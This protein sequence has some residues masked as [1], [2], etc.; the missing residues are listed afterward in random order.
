MNASASIHEIIAHHDVKTRREQNQIVLERCFFCEDKK[1]HFYIS[2][3]DENHPWYCHKCGE[4]GNLITLCRRLDMGEP[5]KMSRV[6]ETIKAGPENEPIPPK[7][8]SRE[9]AEIPHDALLGDEH[10]A[11]TELKKRGFTEETI[12]HFKIGVTTT[13]NSKKSYSPLWQIP[14]YAAGM[15]GQSITCVKYRTIPPADKKMWREAGMDSPLYNAQNIDY[16]ADRVIL[17]EGE[18]D[19][20]ALW[21]VGH[22]NVVSTS[23]GAKGFKPEW[24]QRLSDFKQVILCYDG[25]SAWR[26]GRRRPHQGTS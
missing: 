10:S 3:D 16:A 22:S 21:Q 5:V 23:T 17:C 7:T 26:G 15:F 12:R 14:Y 2:L 11:L 18:F 4:K 24:I 19:A 13:H 9:W 1:Y 25:D 6:G 8:F 20:M